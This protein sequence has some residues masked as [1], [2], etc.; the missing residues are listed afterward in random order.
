MELLSDAPTVLDVDPLNTIA[1]DPEEENKCGVETEV[2][3]LSR[4]TLSELRIKWNVLHGSN[5]PECLGPNMLNRAFAYHLQERSR[6]GL[7]KQAR[8][9]LKALMASPRNGSTVVA[10]TTPTKPGTKF[11]RE[12]QNRVHEVQALADGNFIYEG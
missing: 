11:L 6:G 8:Q 12:W 7:S 10:H 5:A 3:R 4:L 9:R 2:E 1:T